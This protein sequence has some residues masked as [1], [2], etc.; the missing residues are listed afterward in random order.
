LYRISRLKGNRSLS[1]RSIDLS[2]FILRPPLSSAGNVNALP[3]PPGHLHGIKHLRRSQKQ[4]CPFRVQPGCKPF[5]GLPLVTWLYESASVTDSRDALKIKV[6]ERTTLDWAGRLTR[7]AAPI[8][9]AAWRHREESEPSPAFPIP[10]RNCLEAAPAWA[11]R[12]TVDTGRG[13]EDGR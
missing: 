12:V 9:C 10:P 5:S 7:G 8:G 11:I 6:I 13:I 3:R 1:R 4:H 2:N